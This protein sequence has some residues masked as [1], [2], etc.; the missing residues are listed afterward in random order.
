M[1]ML[2]KGDGWSWSGRGGGEHPRREGNACGVLAW[3]H[4][5][6]CVLRGLSVS[7]ECLLLGLEA[8]AGQKWR[9]KATIVHA[10]SSTLRSSLLR[11]V[12][13]RPALYTFTGSFAG[14]YASTEQRRPP[15]PPPPPFHDSSV[16]SV[17]LLLLLCA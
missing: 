8:R 1:G 11:R 7:P 17:L 10:G 6:N 2:R 16:A 15:P 14:D 13:C 9:A 4:G 5:P 12:T 3:S